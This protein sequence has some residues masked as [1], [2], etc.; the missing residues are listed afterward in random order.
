MLIGLALFMVVAGAGIVFL[1]ATLAIGVVSTIAIALL[2]SFRRTR[3]IGIASAAAGVCGAVI[4]AALYVAIDSL[5]LHGEPAM[6]L[7]LISALT[8]FAWLGAAACTTG[9]IALVAIETIK[10]FSSPA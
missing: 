3:T 7:T 10:R 5:A 9:V 4:A 2:V 8:G 6:S 1:V